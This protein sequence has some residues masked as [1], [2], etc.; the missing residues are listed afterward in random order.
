MSALRYENHLE[1]NANKLPGVDI[2]MLTKFQK[3]TLHVE[4]L[5]TRDFT[6]E[7]LAM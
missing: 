2:I 4:Y 6:T 3:A 5:V 1:R 7:A